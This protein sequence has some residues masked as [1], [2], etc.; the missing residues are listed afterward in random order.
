ME[1]KFIRPQKESDHENPLVDMPLLFDA[2]LTEFA[3]RSFDSASLNDIIKKSG[4]SKGSFYHKFQSK[5]DLYLCLMDVISQRKA[6]FAAKTMPVPDDFF[7]KLRFLLSH[8]LAFTLHEPRYNAFWRRH[9][10]ESNF[11]KDAVQSAFPSGGNGLEKMIKRA[12]ELGQLNFPLSF[13]SGVVNLL[14]N[15]LHTLIQ[16]DMSYEDALAIVN[17][18]VD[19]LKFGLAKHCDVGHTQEPINV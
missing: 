12:I 19:M 4:I 18:L 7:E 1:T 6:A 13:I 15:E 5:I 11:V 16:S 9:L 10:D 14:L 3:A 8:N 17:N 2:A